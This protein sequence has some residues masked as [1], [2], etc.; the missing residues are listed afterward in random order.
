MDRLKK[1]F[2]REGYLT[3]NIAYPSRKYPI[4]RLAEEAVPAGIN[5]CKAQGAVRIHFVTHSLGG[6]LLRYYIKQE[7]IEGL[8][9]TVMLAPPNQGSEIV[10]E[11]GHI[12]FFQSI[13]GP[14]GL[15]LSTQPDSIPN[16]LGPVDYSVGIIAG[17]RH[18]LFDR[19][20]AEYIPGVDDG[21]VSIKSAKLQ[22]MSDFI[23][24]PHSHT[25]IMK[26]DDVIVQVIRFIREGSFYPVGSD[27]PELES[28]DVEH[29][30][31][32]YSD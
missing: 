10:D 7:T 8:G 15:Q 4:E 31:L 25:M 20:F 13:L 5:S 14:A 22:G 27:L 21:K 28:F 29:P 9:H 12:S 18:N 2:E 24:V 11:V 1:A 16:T 26:G 3:S 6:I 17:D 19:Q 32:G 30:F 23:V